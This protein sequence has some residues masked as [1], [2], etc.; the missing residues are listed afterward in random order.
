MW[1]SDHRHWGVCV[2]VCVYTDSVCKW[3]HVLELRKHCRTRQNILKCYTSVSSQGRPCP[4]I[5]A[6]C[7]ICSG[8][9]GTKKLVM[10]QNEVLLWTCDNQRD[11]LKKISM[12]FYCRRFKWS[13]PMSTLAVCFIFLYT[14]RTELRRVSDPAHGQRNPSNLSFPNFTKFECH[15]ITAKLAKKP[16]MLFCQQWEYE[17]SYNI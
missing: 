3:L 6:E 17:E 9:K 5:C 4:L 13:S 2:C 11:I 1:S 12:K 15:F 16:C 14:T 10:L 7:L 8:K